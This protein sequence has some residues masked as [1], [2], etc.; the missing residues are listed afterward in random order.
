MASVIKVNE[1]QNATSGNTGLTVD[2]VGR[3]LLPQVPAFHC[4]KDSAQTTTAN[5]ERVT[6][7]TVFLNQ[8]NHFSSSIFT[9]P[10]AGVYFFSC[11]WL[12]DNTTGQSD[13]YLRKNSDNATFLNRSRNANSS[14]YETT[15]L[16][17][18]GELS[19]NDTVDVVIDVSGKTIYGEAG[20]GGTWTTFMGYL[21]G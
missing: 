11:Q 8:G 20:D 2:S 5:N 12:R 16:N 15:T 1:I 13:V 7:D 18:V 9:A 4:K 6:W 3:V 19:A 21:V 17:W 10:V 14:T